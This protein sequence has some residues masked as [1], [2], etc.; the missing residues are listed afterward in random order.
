MRDFT[1]KDLKTG[2]LLELHDKLSMVL[3]G[4][5][6]GDIASGENWFPLSALSDN[7][8]RNIGHDVSKVYSPKNNQAFLPDGKLSVQYVEDYEIIWTRPVKKETVYFEGKV[9]FKEELVATLSKLM[10]Q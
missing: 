3:L 4:T 8:E 1:K 7:L 5:T 10:S 9:Y 6:K 2:M